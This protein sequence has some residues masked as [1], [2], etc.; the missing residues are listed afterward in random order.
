[1]LARDSELA[2]LWGPVYIGSAWHN[3]VFLQ[4]T[5]RFPVLPAENIDAAILILC[6]VDYNA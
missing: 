1:M 6:P 3:A 5:I 2:S 4:H